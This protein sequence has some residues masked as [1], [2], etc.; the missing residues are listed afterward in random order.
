VL[1]IG[2]SSGIGFAVARAAHDAGADVA[3]ASSNADRVDDAV[4]RL[5]GGEGLR[6]DVTDE[7]AVAGLFAR[8]GPIDHIVFTAA[9]WAQVDHK[10]F[11][12]ID[13]AAEATLFG[14]RFWGALA[15]AK[16]G[17]KRV[18]PGG[19]ITLTNGMAAHRP[20][21]GLAVATAM[22]GAVEHLV[23]GLAIELAPVRVNGVCPGAIRTEAWDELPEGF[24]R[25]Q[26][27]RLAGQL[28]PRVRRAAR[29]G[30][31]LSLP[32]ARH[33]HDWADLACRRGL[34]PER[35]IFSLAWN[36]RRRFSVQ[37]G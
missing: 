3:I 5:C 33:L 18:K 11:A 30:G 8:S 13:I 25:F 2:G 21:K 19:S 27:E 15:V 35:V 14:V 28:I 32:D 31:G 7:G 20:Q 9:D 17:A 29:G 26:E 12:E 22:A 36:G 34:E 10:P 4:A 1:V 6:L 24:R 37:H 16:H 23:M